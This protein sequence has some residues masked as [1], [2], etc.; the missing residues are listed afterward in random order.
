[1]RDHLAELKNQISAALDELDRS[2]GGET[3]SG[4]ERATPPADRVVRQVDGQF[5]RSGARRASPKFPRRPTNAAKAPIDDGRPRCCEC[6]AVLTNWPDGVAARNVRCKKC[7]L[8]R[9]PDAYGGTIPHARSHLVRCEV[10][11]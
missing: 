1:M 2:E 10:L 6:G 8:K 11:G 3:R 9:N 5:R 4:R 7:E